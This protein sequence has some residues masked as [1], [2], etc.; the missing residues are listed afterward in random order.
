MHLLT[1]VYLQ[2]STLLLVIMSVLD[3]VYWAGYH[4]DTASPAKYIR[5]GVYTATF[6]ST[7]KSSTVSG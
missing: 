7:E 5:S 2:C 3:L 1:C 6:V 4:S